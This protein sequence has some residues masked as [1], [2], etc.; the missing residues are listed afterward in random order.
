MPDVKRGGRLR[1]AAR[2]RLGEMTERLEALVACESPTSDREALERCADILTPWGDAAV[3]RKAERIT[4]DGHPHVLWASHDPAVLLLGHF[5]T[6]WPMGTTDAWPFAIHGDTATGPGV[7]DMKTGII[8]ML[9]AAELARD[10][11]RISILLTSDEETGSQTSRELIQ[12]EAKRAGAVLVCEPSAQGGAAKIAR[13][14]VARYQIRIQGRAAHSG[15]NPELGV[16]AAV[17]LAHQVLCL[18]SL[19]DPISGTTV[20]PTILEA[21]T[22]INTVPESASIALDVRAWTREEL[23]SVCRNISALSP[24]LDGAT[25]CVRGGVTRYPLEEAATISLLAVARASARDL[26]LPLPGGVRSG[27][28]SDGN[29]TGALGI[30]TLDGLGAVGGHAHSREEWV[31]L[32]AVPDRVALLATVIDRLCE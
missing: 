7:F 32:S 17:E 15:L 25:L 19:T 14:G 31:D 2:T 22:T 5:D 13:K 27:G 28:G 4:V 30:P 3:G 11:A 16:N 10:P 20:T 29:L 9:A 18:S 24:H 1:H 23:D 6:V 8:Q 21:G 12:R 26:G